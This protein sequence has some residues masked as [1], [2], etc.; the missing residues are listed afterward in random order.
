[1]TW[2]FTDSNGGLLICTEF[3]A[4]QKKSKFFDT[5]QPKSKLWDRVVAL[6]R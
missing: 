3:A 4:I 5:A 2:S 1:M 6:S